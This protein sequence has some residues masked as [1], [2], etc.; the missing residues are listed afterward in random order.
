MEKNDNKK[1]LSTGIKGLDALFY[2][3]IQLE[4]NSENHDGLLI[5]ARGEHG[6][7]KIHLAMQMCEGLYISQNEKNESYDAFNEFYP[8]SSEIDSNFNFNE[9]SVLEML[10]IEKATKIII[11]YAKKQMRKDDKWEKIFDIYKKNMT[12]A[13]KCA[14]IFVEE[15]LNDNDK[16]L[17][18]SFWNE[19]HAFSCYRNKSDIETALENAVKDYD[20]SLSRMYVIEETKDLVLT[21]FISRAK[22]WIK[23][24]G[25]ETDKKELKKFNK[26]ADIYTKIFERFIEEILKKNNNIVNR[27]LKYKDKE[28]VVNEILQNILEGDEANYG[29]KL[30]EINQAAKHH[31]TTKNH[32]DEKILFISLN[33]DGESLKSK[34]YDFYIQRLIRNIKFNNDFSKSS[35]KLLQRMVW[36]VDDSCCEKNKPQ[37]GY[38]DKYGLTSITG[39]NP[40]DEQTYIFTDHIR[41]SFIYYNGRTHGL[42]LRHQNGAKDSADMLLCKLFVP[43]DSLVK[44]IGRDELNKGNRMADGLTSFNNL[45]TII[46]KYLPKDNEKKKLDYIMVDGLSRLTKDEIMQCPFNALSDKLR[47]TCKIGFFTADEKIQSSEI[48]TDIVIDMAIRERTNPDQ[49]YHAL[50]ISKCLYQRNVYGWHSYKMRMA[51][52]EVIPSIHFQLQTRYLMDDVVVDAL[53]PLKEDPYPFWLNESGMYSDETIKSC[54]F[55]NDFYNNADEKQI[56]FDICKSSLKGVLNTDKMHAMGTILNDMKSNNFNKHSFLFIDLNYNRTEFKHKYYSM[57]EQFI[58][59][60]QYDI[61]LFNFKPGYLHADEFMWAIDQQVQAISRNNKKE[62]D[63]DLHYERTHLIVGDL[64]YMSFA[65]PCLNKECLLLPAIATYTKKHHMTNYVYASVPNVTKIKLLDQETEIIRQMWAVIG[66]DNMI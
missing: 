32:N 19:S 57:I 61:H 62:V 34:Y 11:E 24:N 13:R 36:Y 53:L 4:H 22:D 65:Y 15:T 42:H 44:I 1:K 30:V 46:D 59:N 64:N 55:Y 31:N 45:L 10:V 26:E 51:G 6:V 52:I 47:K 48:N 17:V 5:L 50:R 8:L 14:T 12:F 56:K 20:T 66:T 2:G 16:E 41:S 35:V 9:L 33:K 39:R 28:E 49:L 58:K 7:N 18:K 43:E 63:H 27:F 40:N 54:D 25:D 60:N 21:R 38:W 23:K 29:K 3:G 37:N